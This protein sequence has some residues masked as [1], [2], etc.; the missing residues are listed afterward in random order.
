[1]LRAEGRLCAPSRATA[2]LNSRAASHR[3]PFNSSCNSRSARAGAEDPS[4][5]PNAVKRLAGARRRYGATA[6]HR[7][8]QGFIRLDML[9]TGKSRMTH[10]LLAMR[11][12]QMPLCFGKVVATRP[13]PR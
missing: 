6:T 12:V 13:P 3:D 5:G 2:R 4:L 9:E 11:Q 1:M 8:L 7:E 10:D